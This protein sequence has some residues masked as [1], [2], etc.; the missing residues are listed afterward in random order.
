MKH[1]KRLLES[2]G[3]TYHVDLSVI[4]SLTH[5]VVNLLAKHIISSPDR[6]T[7]YVVQICGSSTGD[8]GPIILASVDANSTF[9]DILHA[10]NPTLRR[11]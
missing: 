8:D 6:K 5:K 4:T 2:Y 3:S 9:Y 11:E 7:H 10:K 1:A